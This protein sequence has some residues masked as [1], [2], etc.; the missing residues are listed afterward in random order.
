M[1]APKVAIYSATQKSK[2][3]DTT[4]WKS[5]QDLKLDIDLNFWIE[6]KTGLPEL[7]NSGLLGAKI[8]DLDYV[9]FIHDD[10]CLEHDPR[11]NLERAFKDFDIVGVAGCSRAEI[12][13]PAL[14][15]LMG[16]GL[17]NGYEPSNLHGAVGHIY[18]VYPNSGIGMVYTEKR[19]TH[20][21]YQPHRVVMIDGVFMAFNRKAIETVKFDED[22]PSKW[23]FYD[24]IASLQ[25]TLQGLKVGV[26]DILITHESHGL[27]EFSED[28]KIGERYFMNKFGN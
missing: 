11:S 26:G 21:G 8:E 27:R 13:S 9:M 6:N 1:N 28:W 10:V 14:W 5:V 4:L 15:H 3:E 2:K 7:Y 16:G 24:L 12:K 20:F 23:H 18:T 22:C 25:A 19:I 17:Y